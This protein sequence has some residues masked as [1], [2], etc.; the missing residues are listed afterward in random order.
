MARKMSPTRFSLF[1]DFEGLDDN[2]SSSTRTG[3]ILD[4]GVAIYIGGKAA[5]TGWKIPDRGIPFP[6]PTTATDTTFSD[7]STMF[8]AI[9]ADPS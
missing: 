2:N 6:R 1:Q 8:R 9:S 7:R 3:W 4:R 5:E